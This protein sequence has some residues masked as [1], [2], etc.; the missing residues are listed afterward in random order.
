M[1]KYE[2]TLH[3]QHGATL[4]KNNKEE[5]FNVKCIV[6]NNYMP[7]LD[8]RMSRTV[9]PFVQGYDE[10][11]GWILIEF[12][13]GSKLDCELYVQYINDQIEYQSFIENNNYDEME[14]VISETEKAI[15]FDRKKVFDEKNEKWM[16]YVEEWETEKENK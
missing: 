5:A 13:M 6:T 14:S 8:Y 16:K 10:Q 11:E 15:Y 3:Q 4:A 9:Q 7:S 2:W 12:W 1:L